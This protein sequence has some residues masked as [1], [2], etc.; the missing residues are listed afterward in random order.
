M[1]NLTQYWPDYEIREQAD[2]LWNHEWSKHGTCAASLPTFDS[3]LKY[4]QVGLHLAIGYPI[5][6]WLME[7][8]IRPGGEYRKEAVWD[9]VVEHTGKRP[10]VDCEHLQGKQ[11]IKEIK[12]CFTKEL[13]PTD[14]DGIVQASG[15]LGR[16]M[17]TCHDDKEIYFPDKARDWVLFWPIAVGTGAGIMALLGI[18]TVVRHM[19]TKRQGYESI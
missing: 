8:N 4:F 1:E 5:S 3:E 11:F 7:R 15:P 18:V 2:S 9:A 16:M 17:G 10:H 13:Y 19:K 12:L 6:T 14:C